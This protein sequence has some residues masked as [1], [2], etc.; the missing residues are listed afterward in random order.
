M[1]KRP[2]NASPSETP[3]RLTVL[4]VETPRGLCTLELLQGDITRVPCDLLAVSAFKGSYHPTPG[5]VIGALKEN[6]GISLQKSGPG[7][8]LID[9]EFDLRDQFGIWITRELP[10]ATCRRIL[11]VELLGRIDDQREVGQQLQS[12]LENVFVGL[13]ILEA[14]GIVIRQLALPL[15]GTGQQE[16]AP[17]DIVGPLISKTQDAIARSTSLERVMFV[18]RNPQKARLLLDEIERKFGTVNPS[19]PKAELIAGLM[20]E[21]QAIALKLRRATA[22]AQQRMAE[23]MHQIVSAPIPTTAGIGL[24]ARRLAE[25]VADT[26]YLGGSGDD[27]HKKIENLAKTGVAPWLVS[28]LHTLRVIGNEVVHIRERGNRLPSALNEDDVTVCLFC[29]QRVAQFWLDAETQMT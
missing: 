7:R 22:G 9:A 13:A 14:K 20:K 3:E 21:I 1:S 12:L 18:E 26:R 11:C 2:E 27:L 17:L 6:H 25:T 28:Y 5:T 29:V 19:L 4:G 10:G 15:L 8:A 23:E 24:M 16:I